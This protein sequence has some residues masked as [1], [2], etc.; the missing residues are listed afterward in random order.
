MKFEDALGM[1]YTHS[2]DDCKK[3]QDNREQF[4][5]DSKEVLLVASAKLVE[6]AAQPLPP[7]S[8]KH[9]HK[10]EEEDLYA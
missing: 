2:L 1:N 6:A 9:A 4:I 7:I 8:I 5:H 10:E 3:A